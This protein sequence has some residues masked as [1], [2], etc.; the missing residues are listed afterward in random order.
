[1]PIH[2]TLGCPVCG[3]PLEVRLTYG[4]KSGKPFLMAICPISGRHIR[5]FIADQDYVSQILARLEAT[6][7]RDTP[8]SAAESQPP[9][10]RRS[11]TVLERGREP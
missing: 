11:K 6:Q 10:L 8:A 9:A 2:E 4:R 7:A 1:V 5:A 3:T